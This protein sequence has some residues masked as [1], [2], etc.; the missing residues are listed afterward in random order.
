MSRRRKVFRSP[1]TEAEIRRMMDHVDAGGFLPELVQ[2]MRHSLKVLKL[3]HDK[4]VR[5]RNRAANEAAKAANPHAAA[6]KAKLAQVHIAKKALGLDED[7]YRDVI[8]RVCEQRSA[9]LLGLRELD[10]LLAEFRRLGWKNATRRA[11]AKSPEVRKIYVLWRILR[12]NGHV[13]AT[14][15]DA[16]VARQTRT[17][18]KP[19]GVARPEWLRDDEAR[20]LIEQLKKWIGRVGLSSELK[21]KSGP[22]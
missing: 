19:Q 20:A 14:R 5:L 15:P 12:D 21:P 9:K 16:W 8:F 18:A 4:Q 1:M 2:P 10:A 11:E 6:R 7:T 22:R 3:E 13:A 17:A